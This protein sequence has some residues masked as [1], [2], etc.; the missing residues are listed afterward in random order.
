MNLDLD[1]YLSIN[2]TNF[3]S[4][5]TDVIITSILYIYYFLTHKIVSIYYLFTIDS[6]NIELTQLPI[7]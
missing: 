7:E 6:M 5:L 2:P 4:S 1:L 3:E